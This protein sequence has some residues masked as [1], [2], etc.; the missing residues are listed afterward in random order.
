MSNNNGKT[1]TK[2]TTS[3]CDWHKMTWYKLS[4]DYL[5]KV[6]KLFDF[7][8]LVGNFRL[9]FDNLRDVY[10][11]DTMLNLC[12]DLFPVSIVRKQHGLLEFTIRELTTQI[13]CV[14]LLTILFFVLLFL[15]HIYD[16]VAILIESDIEILSG[17]ARSCKLEVITLFV[18]KYID[19]RSCSI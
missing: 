15:L 7:D 6:K 14:L 3:S 5:S 2:K 16:E 12:A 19:C 17:H 9:Y 18:L 4:K 8:Y 10:L 11:E 1:Q 13:M